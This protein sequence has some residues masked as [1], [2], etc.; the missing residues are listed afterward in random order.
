MKAGRDKVGRGKL[1]YGMAW[2]EKDVAARDRTEPVV[3]RRS[4]ISIAAR[5][6]R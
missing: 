3:R 5:S 4:G 1:S 6:L 2:Y